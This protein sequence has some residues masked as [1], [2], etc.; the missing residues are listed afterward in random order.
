MCLCS[1]FAMA[2]VFRLCFSSTIPTSLAAGF[3]AKLPFF[4]KEEFTYFYGVFYCLDCKPCFC[5]ICTLKNCVNCEIFFIKLYCS[6]V[7][8][9][10]IK[11]VY[12]IGTESEALWSL[13]LLHLSVRLCQSVQLPLHLTHPLDCSVRQISLQFSRQ[14]L[15]NT[16]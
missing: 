11:G 5:S 12:L 2:A 4:L 3:S 7:P 14:M 1:R 10:S 13:C 15:E 9:S 8:I 16:D 6:L